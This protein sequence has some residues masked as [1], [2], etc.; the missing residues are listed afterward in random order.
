M[1]AFFCVVSTDNTP[2]FEPL[3]QWQGKW[4][5]VARVEDEKEIERLR[6]L[7]KKEL[8]EAEYT[9]TVKKK[10]TL[11]QGYRDFR[12]VPVAT[13]AEL[14]AKRPPPGTEAGASAT[15][16]A[17]PK[18]PTIPTATIQQPK[19]IPPR[20]KSFTVPELRNP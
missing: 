19:T 9:E 14:A 1:P 5:G 17:T 6:K 10:A 12:E 18:P 15:P 13:P 8:T 4:F 7:K 3:G 2:T 11:Q 20:R 16:V